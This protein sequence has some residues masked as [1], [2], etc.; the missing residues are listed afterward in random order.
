MNLKKVLT[1]EEIA[2]FIKLI[3]YYTYNQVDIT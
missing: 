2:N 1:K 3:K